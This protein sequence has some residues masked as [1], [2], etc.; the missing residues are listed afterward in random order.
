[1]AI[2]INVTKE[3]GSLLIAAWLIPVSVIRCRSFRSWVFLVTGCFGLSSGFL[4][5]L[6]WIVNVAASRSSSTPSVPVLSQYGPT[7]FILGCVTGAIF[8][9]VVRK[10]E[11]AQ[12]LLAQKKNQR[13]AIIP[14]LCA[15][16][17]P[18]KQRVLQNKQA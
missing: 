11:C 2:K 12:A 14:K 6:S 8:K 10:S 9:F 4:L 18:V 17:K 15:S 16:S 3:S 7:V 1:M 5:F 13:V